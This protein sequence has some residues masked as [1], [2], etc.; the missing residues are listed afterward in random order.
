MTLNKKQKCRW[1]RLVDG[2]KVQTC[3]YP[4]FTKQNAKRYSTVDWERMKSAITLYKV[5]NLTNKRMKRE[6][7]KASSTPRKTCLYLL[8]PSL[9]S[10]FML[11]RF[12]PSCHS[13]GSSEIAH[14][15]VSVTKSM[16]GS[17]LSTH[18]TY[19]QHLMQLRSRRQIGNG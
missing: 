17:V 13:N 9:P 19:M 1:Q 10:C 4:C 7:F 3:K 6:K 14:I 18:P 15:K 11:N 5:T 8:S 16:H 2:R 12:Q